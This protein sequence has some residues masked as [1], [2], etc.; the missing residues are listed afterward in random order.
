MSVV[1]T[2]DQ[3]TALLGDAFLKP[4]DVARA[5]SVSQPTLYRMARRGEFPAPYKLSKHRS[6]FS[7]REVREWM[8][9]RSRA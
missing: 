7:A 8:E 6:A 9:A 3:L 4:K 5:L 2:N 1:M